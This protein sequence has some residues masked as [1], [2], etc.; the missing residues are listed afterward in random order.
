MKTLGVP[1]TEYE[2]DNG[3]TALKAQADAISE[4]LKKDG[5]VLESQKELVAVIAYLQRMGTDIRKTIYSKQLIK[6]ETIFSKCAR[7]RWL[8]HLL[9]DRFYIIFCG[10]TLLGV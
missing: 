7:C 8:S 5:I 4:N 3:N 10:L 9:Y 2:I 6:H 1:Y